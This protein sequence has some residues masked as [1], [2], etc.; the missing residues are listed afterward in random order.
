GKQPAEFLSTHPSH[1]TRIKQFQE[2]MPEALA[3][4]DQ[5]CEPPTRLTD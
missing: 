3:I 5:H 4:R 1:E 2:W